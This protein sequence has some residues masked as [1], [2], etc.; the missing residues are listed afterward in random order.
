M[1]EKKIPTAAG[2][3]EHTSC[4]IFGTRKTGKIILRQKNKSNFEVDLIPREKI[5]P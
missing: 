1:I 4:I 2:R 5:L 3:F